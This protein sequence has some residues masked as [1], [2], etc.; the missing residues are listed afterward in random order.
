MLQN[1]Y[2]VRAKTNQAVLDPSYFLANT[3]GSMP[4]SANYQNLKQICQL[5]NADA[6][7]KAADHAEHIVAEHVRNVQKTPFT[8]YKKHLSILNHTC[9]QLE[10]SWPEATCRAMGQVKENVSRWDDDKMRCTVVGPKAE[11]GGTGEIKTECLRKLQPPLAKFSW[12]DCYQ[13][14]PIQDKCD[15]DL[16]KCKPDPNGTQH[17]MTVMTFDKRCVAHMT[18]WLPCVAP[19]APDDEKRDRGNME[20][21]GEAVKR[22][23]AKAAKAAKEAAKAAKAGAKAMEAEAMEAVKAAKAGAKAMEAEATEAVKAASAELFSYMEGKEACYIGDDQTPTGICVTGPDCGIG[24]EENNPGC[25]HCRLDDKPPNA[26]GYCMHLT[27][28]H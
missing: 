11:H 23:A 22:Q 6:T 9:K 17:Q 5:M 3:Y 7:F 25:A 28:P 2:M 20:T 21:K 19:N 27:R 13:T 1:S 24:T 12:F 26:D 4:T 10:V 16:T 15:G 8:D 18:E 14:H